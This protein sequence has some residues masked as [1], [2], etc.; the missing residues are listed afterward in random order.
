MGPDIVEVIQCT[1]MNVAV[2]AILNGCDFIP[3]CETHIAEIE[4]IQAQVAKF[5]LGLPSSAPNFCAQTEL[6]WKP[7]RQMLFERQIKFYFRVLFLDDSRWVHQALLDHLSGTWSSP[8]LTYISDVRSKLG[9]FS[10]PFQPVLWK[11]LS[12]KYF[13]S[14]T[15]TK[16]SP[17]WWLKPL[18]GFEKLHYVS[19]SKW[20]T[21]I[22][23]FRLGCEGLGNKQPIKHHIRTQW[24][25]VCPHLYQPN[26][27]H[28][29][30]FVCSSLTVLRRATGIA[31]FMTSCTLK[32][33]S[34]EVAYS[35]FISGLDCQENPIS[36]S[37]FYERARCMHDMRELWLSKWWKLC[38]CLYSN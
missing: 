27:G 16:I 4:R 13:L 15:N 21:I 29:L 25:P 1:W 19:E 24:C 36:I 18:E 2:P 22:S 11:R 23:E 30:L 7:F 9:I 10:A 28:H 33:I 3:F 31:S 6:G 5:A 38:K 34:S 20:S 26:D 14:I 12:Y 17:N 32:N 35:L 37:A 8:Y